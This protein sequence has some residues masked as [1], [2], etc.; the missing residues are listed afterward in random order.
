MGHCV[1]SGYGLVGDDGRMLL[2]DMEATPKIVAA[3]QRE[4]AERGI[5][6]RAAREPREEEMVTR[7][8]E[9]RRA[10]RDSQ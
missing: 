8:A 7:S 5:R 4:A 2:L 1:D 6:L 9:L 10:E 3:V